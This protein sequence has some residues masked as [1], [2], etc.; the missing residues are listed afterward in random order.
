MK[1][2]KVDNHRPK[3]VERKNRK[4]LILKK[5]P[6]R[7]NSFLLDCANSLLSTSV[8]TSQYGTFKR[9]FRNQ[10]M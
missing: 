3:K 5:V 8:K 2:R 6:T 1:S 9:V 7:V 4:N 10:L